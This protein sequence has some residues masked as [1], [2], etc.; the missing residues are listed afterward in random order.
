[1]FDFDIGDDMKIYA[2]GMKTASKTKRVIKKAA[3]LDKDAIRELELYID[4]TKKLYDVFMNM[5]KNLVNKQARG[6]YD[7]NKAVKLFEYLALQ[8]AEAYV[9]EHGS[10]ND[11]ATD[12]F[13]KAERTEVAKGLRDYFEAEA[14]LGNF[15]SLLAKKY[16]KPKEASVFTKRRPSKVAAQN[17]R[18]NVL[19]SI[20]D[21]TASEKDPDY[22]R[23]VT[24][25]YNEESGKLKLLGVIPHGTC[26]DINPENLKLL[27]ST[28]RNKH[29]K[30]ATK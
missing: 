15:D 13:P 12:M 21:E 30:D 29:R 27:I 1:M 10:K 5:A 6:I 2:S 3:A 20:H 24:L 7:S 23:N 22:P 11:R 4:N 16:Q 8:G 14:E 25:S 18:A 28:L 9:K 17:K 19:I 26:I